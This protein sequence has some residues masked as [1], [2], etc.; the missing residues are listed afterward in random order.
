[1]TRGATRT[2][3][4]E[5]RY[6]AALGAI[7]LRGSQPPLSW[8]RTLPPTSA[9]GC[10]H[11][12][13]IELP[14]GAIVEF[15]PLRDDKHWARERNFT[16]L[17][18][19]RVTVEP[20]FDRSRSVVEAFVRTM[21]WR[22]L[23]RTMAFQVLLPPS[24]DEHL[25]KRYPVLYAQDGQALF[26]TGADPI[27]GSSWR[28]DE[29]LDE[30][31]EIGALEEII[32][33]GIHTQ[34][35][36]IDV[37]SPT[38]DPR[39]GGGDGPK[40]LQFLVDTVKPW[41]DRTYRTRPETG[42]TALLGASMGGLFSFFA[43]WTR[44]D[45]FGKAACLSGSFWWDGRSMVREVQKGYCPAPRPLLYIDSGAAKTHFEE[46]ANARDG[47]HHTLALRQALV[48]HCYMPGDNLHT[49]AFP[50]LRHNNTSWGVRL[51]I[52]LQLLFPRRA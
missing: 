37:L 48:T 10:S 21:A 39:H 1:M 28:M 18:G 24:Y 15:K 4:I 2:T 12:F 49:L 8:D 25:D 32:V 35:R 29:T 6:P 38:R 27:D 42:S 52:P 13:E 11:V 14:E 30:L 46:D 16:V 31:Y 22:E 45:V 20:Y 41:V 23:D 5:V 19:E 9:S 34:E 7:G 17:A 43:A 40:Y 33:V 50:G 44:P 36:R 47:L 51:P 3:T 26:S